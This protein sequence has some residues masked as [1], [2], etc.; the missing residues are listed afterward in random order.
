MQCICDLLQGQ[1]RGNVFFNIFHGLFRELA[2]YAGSVLEAQLQRMEHFR[3]G[4]LQSED[5][6]SQT[7]GIQ[8]FRVETARFFDR[9]AGTD[10]IDL[11]AD[12]LDILCVDKVLLEFSK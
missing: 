7:D 9:N 2:L 6:V 12:R 11:G 3:D 8:I 10:V 4:L 5:I 1:V